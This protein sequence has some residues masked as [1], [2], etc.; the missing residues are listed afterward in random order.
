MASPLPSGVVHVGGPLSSLHAAL[1]GDVALPGLAFAFHADDRET[2]RVLQ[3]PSEA[4]DLGH[5]RL[6]VTGR[7]GE[8]LRD[9]GRELSSQVRPR[10]RRVYACAPRPNGKRLEFRFAEL[11]LPRHAR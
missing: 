3:L 2:Q 5:E 8:E 10:L 4:L 11:L 6:Y 9:V 1:L 7:T